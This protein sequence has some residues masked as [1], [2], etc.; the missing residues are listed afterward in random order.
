MSSRT[1]RIIVSIHV[2]TWFKIKCNLSKKKLIFFCKIRLSIN[3][4]HVQ[5]LLFE[6]VV[7]WW[8]KTTLIVDR[9]TFEL[10]LLPVFLFCQ[11]ET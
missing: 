10:I 1:L 5:S 9:Q 8:A 4:L 11:L 3:F 6:N 2:N 7:K